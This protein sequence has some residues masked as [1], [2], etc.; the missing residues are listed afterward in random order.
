MFI[1]FRYIKPH[2][3]ARFAYWRTA[4]EARSTRLEV[5]G[6]EKELRQ[7]AAWLKRAKEHAYS[8]EVARREALNQVLVTKILLNPTI[9]DL[10]LIEARMEVKRLE[11]DDVPF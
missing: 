6:T 9:H 7:L 8:A 4:W 1:E 5:E 2:L 10:S 3:L 11:G